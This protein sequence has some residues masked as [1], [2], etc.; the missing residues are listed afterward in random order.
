MTPHLGP[1]FKVIRLNLFLDIALSSLAD[2]T[3]ALRGCF[4]A[5]LVYISFRFILKPSKTS[6][7][8][9]MSYFTF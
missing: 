1:L 9:D 2:I 7:S 4:P 3:H 8:L 6:N 5:G